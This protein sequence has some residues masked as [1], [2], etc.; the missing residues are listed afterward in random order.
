M[1]ILHFTFS[2]SRYYREGVEVTEFDV[3]KILNKAQYKHLVKTGK[4]NIRHADDSNKSSV[5]PKRT[6]KSADEKLLAKVRKSYRV[7][8]VDYRT[9]PRV[10]LWRKN[11]KGFYNIVC[12][13]NSGDNVDELIIKDAKNLKKP[14]KVEE[15]DD[16]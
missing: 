8:T 6:R 7:E 10:E 15:D 14:I 11:P 16:V 1:K 12:Y 13:I 4:V 5:V 2:D 3:K 9:G